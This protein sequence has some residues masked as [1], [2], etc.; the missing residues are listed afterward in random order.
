MQ[1]IVVAIAVMAFIG[2]GV[3]FGVGASGARIFPCERQVAADGSFTYGFGSK[4]AV[5]WKETTCRMAEFRV[6][7]SGSAYAMMFGMF[8]IG[9]L[10]I[11]LLLGGSAAKKEPKTNAVTLNL[12]VLGFAGAIYPLIQVLMKGRRADMEIMMAILAGAFFVS[13]LAALI[14]RGGQKLALGGPIVGIG[15]MV[16]SML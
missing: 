15:M 13:M 9:P 8:L 16:L 14:S 5:G 6:K 3:L 10:L 1:R 11:G 7:Y 12:A 4:E 2:F